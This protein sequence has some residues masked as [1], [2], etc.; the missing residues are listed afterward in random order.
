MKFS[1]KDKISVGK[2]FMILHSNHW[3]KHLKGSCV[4]EYGRYVVIELMSSF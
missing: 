1:N 4:Q 2:P 3:Q